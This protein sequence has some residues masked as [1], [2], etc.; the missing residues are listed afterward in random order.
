MGTLTER[1]HLEDQSVNGRTILKRIFKNCDGN[2]DW[3]NVAE[4]EDRCR[5]LANALMN[6]RFPY[7][8]RIS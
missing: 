2:V 5:A 6:L 3:I 4:D 7:N 8:A 1:A